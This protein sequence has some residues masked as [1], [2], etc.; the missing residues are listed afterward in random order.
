MKELTREQMKK[1]IEANNK[2]AESYK[3]LAKAKQELWA[4]EC[5]CDLIDGSWRNTKM[6]YW[7]DIC[8]KYP[9][10]KLLNCY[11]DIFY[12]EEHKGNVYVGRRVLWNLELSEE[13]YR[14]IEY[15]EWDSD[16][17]YD[18]FNYEIEVREE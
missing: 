15:I 17:S 12:V 14:I 5:E 10:E 9:E 1:I 4:Y 18:G 16:D 2:V 13:Q 11:G 7:K 8:V 6:S 3:D